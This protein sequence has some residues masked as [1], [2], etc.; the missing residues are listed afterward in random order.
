MKSLLDIFSTQVSFKLA[1]FAFCQPLSVS[2]DQRFMPG[3]IVVYSIYLY[4]IELCSNV[5]IHF[6]IKQILLHACTCI[7]LSWLSAQT[8]CFINMQCKFS[9]N[10]FCN[11]LKLLFWKLCYLKL[12]Q[13]IDWMH[14]CLLNV[15]FHWFNFY[16]N[17]CNNVKIKS[18][19]V[20]W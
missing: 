18:K 13:Y 1:Y 5:I 12:F 19:K 2:W 10:S 16:F 7:S 6:F 11:G 4:T 3:F 9:D 8:P 20:V 14:S 17:V 15:I